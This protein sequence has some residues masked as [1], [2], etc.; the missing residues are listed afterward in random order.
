MN[1]FPIVTFEPIPLETANSLL[2]KWAHKMGPCERGNA[3]GWSH[4]LFHEGEPVAVTISATLIREVVG[5]VTAISPGTILSNSH[6]CAQLAQ[7]CVGSHCVYGVN[8]F[9]QHYRTSK[10][11]PIKMPT[12]I[13]ATLT[14]LMDGSVSAKSPAAAPIRDQTEKAGT[15][16]FGCFLLRQ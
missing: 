9:F 1:L 11:F 7:V 14:D 3:R 8:L 5:G 16:G 12:F 10:P 6:A 13:T 4:A 15:S 2:I